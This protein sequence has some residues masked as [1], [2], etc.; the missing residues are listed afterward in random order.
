MRPASAAGPVT[1]R[2]PADCAVHTGSG[3][4]N[5]GQQVWCGP[6]AASEQEVR[7]METFVRACQIKTSM[8]FHSGFG[9]YLYPDFFEVG[10]DNFTKW[11]GRGMQAVHDQAPGA[12]PYDLGGAGDKLC[13]ATESS[14]DFCRE[15]PGNT[16]PSRR[17]CSPRTPIRCAP[18][19][20]FHSCRRTRSG[21]LSLNACAHR[22]R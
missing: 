19:I 9:I 4:D 5:V 17:S 7:T 10:G 12:V 20:C 15:A 3:G 11:L 2:N 21:R 16:P 18:R 6:S 13:S 14:M 8:H 1:S 22:S